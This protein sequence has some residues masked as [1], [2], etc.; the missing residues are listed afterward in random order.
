[1]RSN[2]FFKYSISAIVHPDSPPRRKPGRPKGSKNKKPRID[3]P[4]STDAKLPPMTPE[5][6]VPSFQD[7]IRS[8]QQSQHSSRAKAPQSQSHVQNQSLSRSQQAT[9]TIHPPTS[10]GSVSAPAPVP[11]PV[12]TPQPPQ[13]ATGP[14]QASDPNNQALY[15]FQWRILN[16]CSEF[17][18]AADE[19]I[20]SAF[21]VRFSFCSAYSR[22]ISG[23]PRRML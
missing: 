17:Y 9:S 11:A 15:D 4:S 21:C 2:C 7:R 16:L 6:V 12:S 5:V 1:M 13:Q 3:G 18:N 8:P 14:H 19:L 22:S 20:V 10:S 23:K